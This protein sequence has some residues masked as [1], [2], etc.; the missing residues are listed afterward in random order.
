M[1]E[2]LHPPTD[3]GTPPKTGD[4]AE[5]TSR[6]HLV[7]S[8]GKPSRDTNAG[9]WNCRL[10][11]TS[12]AVFTHL[13]EAS[14]LPFNADIMSFLLKRLFI[15]ISATL[16]PYVL[17]VNDPVLSAALRSE[18]I[19][20]FNKSTGV[21]SKNCTYFTSAFIHPSLPVHDS[22]NKATQ[23]GSLE[24]IQPVPAEHSQGSNVNKLLTKSL[25]GLDER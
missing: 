10:V 25:K 19:L 13:L 12:T 4:A 18:Y 15:S 9:C 7:F 21:G 22:G 3:T 11:E 14:I 23:L 17:P 1:R 20:R 5:Q 16:I 2:T 24:L 6:T 8:H